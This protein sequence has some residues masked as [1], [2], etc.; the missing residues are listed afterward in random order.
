MMETIKTLIADKEVASEKRDESK[1]W[2]KEEVVKNYFEIQTK[3]LE[4]EDINARAAAKE[5]GQQAEGAGDPA[6]RE[7]QD[8]GD[9]LDRRHGPYLGAW[10][11]KKKIIIAREM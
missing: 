7:D 4:I 2:E 6:L 5:V 1:R 3:K 9:P 8:H 11:E 10:L